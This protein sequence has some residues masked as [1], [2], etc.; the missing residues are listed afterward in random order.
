DMDDLPDRPLGRRVVHAMF[1]ARMGREGKGKADN[2]RHPAA[3]FVIPAKAGIHEHG[4]SKPD[5]AVFMDPGSS[6]G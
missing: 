2:G 1:L 6:P 4:R 5:T 3:F